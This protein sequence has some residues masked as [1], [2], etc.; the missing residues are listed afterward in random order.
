M[1]LS[2]RRGAVV[3]VGTSQD[4]E[5]RSKTR[6]GGLVG[7]FPTTAPQLAGGWQQPKGTRGGSGVACSTCGVAAASQGGQ[8]SAQ[9]AAPIQNT[10]QTR[11]QHS[12]A[13]ALSRGP[14]CVSSM[15][16]TELRSAQCPRAHPAPC[17]A[18]GPAAAQAG[19]GAQPEPA[20]PTRRQRLCSPS[21]R[22]AALGELPCRDIAAL[23]PLPLLPLLCLWCS[24]KPASVSCSYSHNSG[25]ASQTISVRWS[26]VGELT[27]GFYPEPS[28]R[29]A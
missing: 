29:W 17:S 21:S 19:P 26:P 1:E 18:R 2:P 5:T 15:G 28:Q 10:N 9:N 20:L 4:T 24:K 11:E 27:T 14:G 8:G 7:V 13:L 3:S 6:R 23:L 12:W 25:C 22:Q 16:S